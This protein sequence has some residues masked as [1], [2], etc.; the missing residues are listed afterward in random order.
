M[1][2]NLRL[3]LRSGPRAAQAGLQVEVFLPRLRLVELG[4]E[5][6]LRIKGAGAFLL[7]IVFLTDLFRE[8][9]ELTAQIRLVFHHAGTERLGH[10]FQEILLDELLHHGPFLVHDAVDAKVQLGTVELEE[11]AEEGLELLAGRGNL[12]RHCSRK[13]PKGN[14]NRHPGHSQNNRS[15]PLPKRGHFLA[16]AAA[17]LQTCHNDRFA[18]QL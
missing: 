3:Q 18:A 15:R 14:H 5:I 11:L 6:A 9:I 7:V 12:G 16:E 8:F 10:T 2:E 17:M 1:V 4:S 13:S